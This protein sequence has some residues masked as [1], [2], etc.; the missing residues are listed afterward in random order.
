MEARIG[1]IAGDGGT[2]PLRKWEDLLIG[3][4]RTAESLVLDDH[5]RLIG[6][7]VDTKSVSLRTDIADIYRCVLGDLPL[8]AEVPV[9]RVRC[10]GVRIDRVPA[11]Q[12]DGGCARRL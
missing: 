11:N 1:Q 5:V 9:V 2:G 12:A 7:N 4:L 10:L 3:R 6:V 8:D